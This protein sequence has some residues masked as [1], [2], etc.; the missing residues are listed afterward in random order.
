MSEVA[1]CKLDDKELA[2]NFLRCAKTVVRIRLK[3]TGSARNETRGTA[4]LMQ[5]SFCVFKIRVSVVRFRTRPPSILYE[6]RCSRHNCLRRCS[7]PR[8]RRLHVGISGHMDQCGR[9]AGCHRSHERLTCHVARGACRSSRH[10]RSCG[11]IPEVPVEWHSNLCAITDMTDTTALPPLPDQLSIDPR[12]PH[13]VAAVF[14]H[15]IGI[16]FNDT[17]R[18]DVEEYCISGG[19]IRVRAGKALDRKGQ[20]LLIKLKGKVEAFYR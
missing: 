9:S 14:E 12:S 19:W 15:E 16:R 5:R 20:P 4:S 3:H 1:R 11:H 6:I 13:H 8:A 18:T 2:S 10:D 7:L 17:E